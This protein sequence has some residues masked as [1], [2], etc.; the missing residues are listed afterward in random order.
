MGVFAP[1]RESLDHRLRMASDVQ[2]LVSGLLQTLNDHL[3]AYL[4]HVSQISP[5]QDLLD[6]AF[7]PI[8]KDITLL[9]RLSNTI[10]KA[11]RQSQNLRAAT[12]FK[13]TDEAGDD[14]G[15]IFRDLF[16][17]DLIGRK[18][19]ACSDSL[20][21]RLASAMLLRRKRILY[22]RSRHD[23]LME[24]HDTTRA[25][26]QAE[27][28][29]AR[30]K[31]GS[32]ATTVTP[33]QF[34]KASAASVV[35]RAPTLRLSTSESALFPPAPKA[36]LKRRLLSFDENQGTKPKKSRSSLK[37]SALSIEP[38]EHAPR[39]PA[40]LPKLESTLSGAEH[41]ANSMVEYD[42]QL[43]DER[44]YEVVCPYCCCM[45]SS[46]D[47]MDD[48]KWRNHVKHDLDAYVCLFENC[49]SADT[50]YNHSDEWLNHMRG[51]K[52]RWRCTA[53]AHGKLF[54]AN[55]EEYSEHIRATHKASDAQVQF[56]AASIGRSSSPIFSSCPLCGVSELTIGLEDHVAAHLRYLALKSLPFIDADESEGPNISVNSSAASS[57]SR[58]TINEEFESDSLLQPGDL[59]P[60]Y[61]EPEPS[62][63]NE[64]TSQSP[65]GSYSPARRGS[66]PGFGSN[67]DSRDDN[68]MTSAREIRISWDIE[69]PTSSTYLGLSWQD[70]PDIARRTQLLTDETPGENQS[71]PRTG[72]AEKDGHNTG[73]E[74]HIPGGSQVDS[75]SPDRYAR[76]DTSWLEEWRLRQETDTF[77]A[78]EEEVTFTTTPDA[79]TS[80]NNDDTDAIPTETRRQVDTLDATH[81]EAGAGARL[82]N[83]YYIR[84]EAA[85]QEKEEAMRHLPKSPPSPAEAANH[86]AQPN[87][88]HDDAAMALQDD[89]TPQ[90]GPERG[91]NN[92]TAASIESADP[93]IAGGS[94][95]WD[96]NP[97]PMKYIYKDSDW[98]ICCQCG[99]GPL[100]FLVTPCC[101]ECHHSACGRCTNIRRK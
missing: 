82:R 4:S 28:S 88:S 78:D 96:N 68:S 95:D 17:R 9:H 97:L 30:S 38:D 59:T 94:T 11:G 56:L 99:I 64:R 60:S 51:H 27:P 8:S 25:V 71:G 90:E 44:K 57:V 91:I 86:P 77:D 36:Q 40:K 54:F 66:D 45:L 72:E 41:E 98:W 67:K 70:V 29:A 24:T 76:R 100:I 83:Q 32:G 31:T 49:N 81:P 50:L 75:D 93:E 21:E 6:T 53:K 43:W 15:L 61:A 62:H 85:R 39:P 92:S 47:V 16:A 69:F 20:Q 79:D 26:N 80:R 22:R 48:N 14:V 63:D 35:M 87:S 33:E 37:H 46:T 55:Q 7:A 19:P 1:S 52:L 58:S 101:L 18:F 89:E 42:T 12:D 2:R 65:K 3:R 10:R 23:R 13:I 74:Q 84:R 5:D 73:L 34:K